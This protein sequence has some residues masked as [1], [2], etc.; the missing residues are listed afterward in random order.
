MH[1][2]ALA[3][4]LRTLPGATTVDSSR[5]EGTESWHPSWKGGWASPLPP[6]MRHLLRTLVLV[7]LAPA[8]LAHGDVEVDG[9]ITARTDTTV[10]VDASVFLLTSATEIRDD[11]GTTTADALT[12]GRRVEAE[13]E[14]SGDGVLVA[15]KIDIEDDDREIRFEG[16]ITARDG[17][18]LRVGSVAVRIT[19]QTR[20]DGDEGPATAEDLV[21]G[22]HVEV[23]GSLDAAGQVVADRIEVDGPDDDGDDEDTEVKGPIEDLGPASLTVLG[24]TFAVTDATRIHDGATVVPFES[25]MV[26]Q[27]VEVHG[28]YA[29]DGVLVATRVEVEDFA[30]DE[31]ELT[32]AIEAL[33]PAALTV[34]GLRFEVT[35][36]TIVL[37]DDRLPILFETLVLGQFVEIRADIVASGVRQATHIKAEDV[38]DDEVE[39]TAALDAVGDGVVVALGRAFAVDSTTV[40]PTG[41]SAGDV[42]ELHARL[43]PGGDLLASQIEREDRPATQVELRGPVTGVGPDSLAV[44]G[45]PFSVDGATVI[46]GRDG[47]PTTLDAITAGASVEVWADV[48]DAGWLATRIGV[49]AAARATGRATSATPTGFV[50]GDVAVQM[51]AATRI[52]SASGAP[53]AAVETGQTVAAVG[54]SGAGGLLATRVVVLSEATAVGAEEER[55]VVV[56]A[57]SVAPNP[58]VTAGRLRYDLASASTVEIVV[59][60]TLGREVARLGPFAQAAGPHA[61]VLDVSGLPS[62]VYLV[63]LVADG[64]VTGG[65]LA[66]TVAR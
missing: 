61:A 19:G 9:F 23:R 64:S 29:A 35:D 4:R 12:V 49:R 10:T 39:L 6:A 1:T 31:V 50:V 53:L 57:L 45:V 59:Y 5:I 34:A 13:G 20:I 66:L 51:T 2:C 7:L 38:L 65:T 47:S 37:D 40:M 28:A 44:I 30:D 16:P 25:L 17:D 3:A 14:V 54:T 58:L 63:R 46:V 36:A 48:T 8:A 24:V 43:A 22:T 56:T 27:L 60:S 41:L 32:G 62:G 42:V 26:G 21:V 52:V 11:D 18:L 33:E 15:T 55:E